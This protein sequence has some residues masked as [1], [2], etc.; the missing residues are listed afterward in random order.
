MAADL[1]IHIFEG[2]TEE[3]LADFNSHT[4]GSKYFDLRRPQR[5]LLDNPAGET[6]NVWIGEVSWLK[7]GLFEDGEQAYIPDTVREISRLIGEDLP[8][9]D[10]ELIK[11]IGDAF[12]LP[13]QTGYSLSEGEEVLA[14][15]EQHKGKKAYTISW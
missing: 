11:K 14:F 7:A 1:H 12:D 2:I 5:S 4:L 9:L 6:P 8:V 3:D 15:L 13:N 10:D